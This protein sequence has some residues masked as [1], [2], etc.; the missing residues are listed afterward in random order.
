MRLVGVIDSEAGAHAFSD[1]LLSCGYPNEVD[2][3]ANGYS[4]WIHHDRH[5]EEAQIEFEEF[6][7]DRDNPKY[8]G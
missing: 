1:Y 5:L 2:E 7:D 6:I 8:R 3:G 4:I